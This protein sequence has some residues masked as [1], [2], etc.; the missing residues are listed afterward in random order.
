MGNWALLEMI[1]NGISEENLERGGGVGGK[2][3]SFW[4]RS[5]DLVA[6]S[7]KR[8]VVKQ[9]ISAVGSGAEWASLYNKVNFSSVAST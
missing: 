8:G 7:S 2:V 4:L 9:L 5:R 6:G 1:L 3:A